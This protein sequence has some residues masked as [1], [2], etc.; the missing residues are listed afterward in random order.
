MDQLAPAQKQEMFSSAASIMSLQVRQ[1]IIQSITD[2]VTV[3]TAEHKPYRPLFSSSMR[4][5]ESASHIVL[6]PPHPTFETLLVDL[7]DY[8]AGALHSFVPVH[9]WFEGMSGKHLHVAPDQEF[10]N[11][12]KARLRALVHAHY[13][14][15]LQAI[16]PLRPHTSLLAQG[17]HA[18]AVAQFLAAE[19][20]FDEYKK[21]CS[22]HFIAPVSVSVCA[23]LI[24]VRR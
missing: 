8:F 18:L 22:S 1:L 13:I 21:V 24:H 3:F 9:I 16:E 14:D 20:N 19:H 6:Q 12:S 4:L 11:A 23:D 17:E 15:P 5:D 10:V 7:I 2:L